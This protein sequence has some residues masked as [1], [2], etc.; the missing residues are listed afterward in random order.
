MSDNRDHEKRLDWGHISKIELA[1]FANEFDVEF[2]KVK[3]DT[4][5]FWPKQLEA[6]YSHGELKDNQVSEAKSS[7][8]WD[9]LNLNGCLDQEETLNTKLH[10]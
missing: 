5:F 3:N 8:G 7:S 1:G 4:I 9:M 6:I 2:E 10:L